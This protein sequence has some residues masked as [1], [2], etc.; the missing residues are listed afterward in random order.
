MVLA[1]QQVRVDAHVHCVEQ[2]L[3]A[4]VWLP[5]C[6]LRTPHTTGGATHRYHVFN[7]WCRLEQ[8]AWRVSSALD[9][10]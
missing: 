7:M 1:S 5:N 6:A 2:L 3:S 10:L 9:L 4:E 8:A